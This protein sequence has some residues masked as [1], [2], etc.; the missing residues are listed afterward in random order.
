MFSTSLSISRQGLRGNGNTED[1]IGYFL[2]QS[3][4]LNIFTKCPCFKNVCTV[5]LRLNDQV[6]SILVCG[7]NCVLSI[8]EYQT[9]AFREI[10]YSRIL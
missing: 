3:H 4:P 10:S 1:D 7:R 6:N 2:F 8:K 5:C 9:E